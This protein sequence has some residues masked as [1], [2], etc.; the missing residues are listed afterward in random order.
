MIRMLALVY[1]NTQ[2]EDVIYHFRFK[3]SYFT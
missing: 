1:Y 2:Y 3:N